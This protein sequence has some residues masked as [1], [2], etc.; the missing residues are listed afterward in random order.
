MLQKK[1][2]EQCW[3]K[4]IP[5][6]SERLAFLIKRVDWKV[7]KSDEHLTFEQKRFKKYFILMNEK[8]R[9]E[10]K[11]NIEKDFCKLMNNSNFGYDCW[12]KFDNCKFVPI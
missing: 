5:L 10:W 8:S 12:N 4:I 3:K 9:Q 6:Y 1:H 11:N 2:V 7:T